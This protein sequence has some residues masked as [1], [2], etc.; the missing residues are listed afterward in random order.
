MEAVPRLPMLSFELKVSSDRYPPEFVNLKQY[1][2]DFYNEDP[3]T[4]SAEI[5]NLETLRANAVHPAKDATGCAVMKKYFCQL[6]FLQSRFPIGREDKGAISF[7]W[8]DAYGGIVCTTSD[9][10]F[11]MVNILYNIGAL[12]SI[13]GAGDDRTTPEGLKL[14]CTHFQCAAWAFQHLKDSYP[15]PQGLDCSP[16][17]MQFMYQLCLAQAQECI[18][19]K[20]MTDNRK[21]TIN[22]KVAAQIVDYYNLA[23]NALLQGSPEDPAIIDIVGSKFFKSWKRYIKFKVSYYCC[24]S[25]LYQGMQSEEQQKMGERIA[26]FQGALDKLN[27]AIKLSKNIDQGEIV[28]EALIFT[29]DVVEGKRKAAKNENDFIYHEDIPELDTLP[30]IKGA[31]LVKGIPFSVN[32]PEISGPDIFARLVPMKAHEVSSLYSEEKAKLLRKISAMIDA[33]DEEIVS[34]MSSLQLDYLKVHLDSPVLPQE[35]VDRCAALSAKPDAIQNL[36]AAMDKLSDAYHDVDGMLKEVMELIK[37]EEVSEK[38]YQE[39]M[40]PRPPSIVATDLTRE[41]NKYMEAHKKAAESN[42]TLHKAMTQHI[43]NLRVLQQPLSDI[44]NNLPSLDSLT[45]KEDPTIKEVIML[46]DKVGE[47]RKQRAM[48][49]SQLRESVCSDDITAQLVTRV[50]ERKE[51]IFEKE[52]QKHNKYVS[53]IEQNLSA[54]EKILP[55][56]T[57]AYARYA[58]TRKAVTEIMRQ[59]EMMLSALISSYDAYE[60]LITKSNKGLEFYRKL[61]TNLTKLLQRVKGTCKVQQEERDTIL[62]QNNKKLEQN[63][64]TSSSTTLKLKDYLK[65]RKDAERAAS[66]AAAA[67]YYS[68]QPGVDSQQSWLPSVRPAPLG[69]EGTST[70][71]DYPSYSAGSGYGAYSQ[72]NYGSDYSKGYAVPY[73]YQNAVTPDLQNLQYPSLTAGVNMES[74]SQK[75][76]VPSIPTAS[77][78]SYPQ[79]AVNPTSYGQYEQSNTLSNQYSSLNQDSQYAVATTSSYQPTDSQ[80][81]QQPMQQPHPPVMGAQNFQALDVQQQTAPVSNQLAASQ[82]KSQQYNPE[83]S[84]SAYTPNVAATTPASN[85]YNPQSSYQAPIN[86]DAYQNPYQYGA[87]QWSQQNYGYNANILAYSNPNQTATNSVYGTSLAQQN[88]P[89]V[90]EQQLAPP[91]NQLGQTYNSLSTVTT[92]PSQAA[93]TIPLNQTLNTTNPIPQQYGYAA[94]SGYHQQPMAQSMPP[95]M[96]DYSQYYQNYTNTYPNMQFQ[97]TPGTDTSHYSNAGGKSTLETNSSSVTPEGLTYASQYTASTV[98][99]QYPHYYTQPYGYQYSTVNLNATEVTKVETPQPLQSK[100]MTYMQADGNQSLTMTYSQPPQAQ[101]S[102]PTTPETVTKQPSNLDLLTG[103][104]FSMTDTP[105]LQPQLNSSLLD[106]SQEK[107]ANLS[108]EPKPS[109]TTVVST[110]NVENTK[111]STKNGSTSSLDKLE[112]P[113]PSKTPLKDPFLDPEVLSQFVQEV[114][115]FEKF[116]EGLNSKTLNG[117]T[118]LDIKWNELQELQDKDAHKQIISVARCYPM[119]NR[120]PDILP[121]D[122]TRVELPSTKDDYINASHAKELRPYAPNFIMT[123]APLPSTYSDFWT[124]VLEQHVELVVCLLS[125][126]QMNQEIYWAVNKTEDLVLGKIKVSFQSQN[127]KSHWIERIISV[128]DGK[129]SRVV[130]HL[131]FTSWPH[132]WMPESPGPFLMLVSEAVSIWSQQRGKGPIVVHCDSGVGKTGLFVL[133]LISI[134]DLRVSPHLPDPINVA[135]Q[136]ASFRKNPLRDRAHLSFAYHCVL[137]HARDLLMKRGILASRSTFEEKRTKTKSHTRHPSE[138]FLLNSFKEQNEERRRSD[139]SSTGSGSKQLNENDPLSQIDPLWP[140]KRFS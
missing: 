124:M 117:P 50:D 15:Q 4:Y 114:E 58:P 77:P 70:K 3:E 131:Q 111:Q 81:L 71:Q 78:Y 99:S 137:Y 10:K 87:Q 52:M 46:V 65:S 27:E 118:P 12:H 83:S 38:E 89:Y 82:V 86:Y 98:P 59:R 108:I 75:N 22:A 51:D 45:L 104:D 115:K 103:L 23:L 1:I 80:Y 31:S 43:E 125:D 56:L 48:L 119:K 5:R 14:A 61:E 7:V 105:P 47:M 11:E 21:A 139:A 96:N 17:L 28:N 20:S 53:L 49:A 97:V 66:A 16:D 84:I 34:Y 41:A 92:D 25:L 64:D 136:I 72:P 134:C 135:G 29:R 73:N 55:A 120:F 63:I 37:I 33:K 132:S 68:S 40:G 62:A 130:V 126:S 109:T 129:T 26:Y 13:L 127:N 79:A 121:Y 100:S 133:L 94:D 57:D 107:M 122:C 76:Y 85:T 32:D 44:A 112:R 9:I 8:K 88:I 18:L 74:P 24:I 36:I 106:T 113:S 93:A 2:R 138:D 39:I 6:H 67:S 90:S 19:E 116:V 123:Q 35:V 128:S 110:D 95:S 101:G 30:P 102:Q 140:I 54:Q 69:S 91:A 42:E 60:D